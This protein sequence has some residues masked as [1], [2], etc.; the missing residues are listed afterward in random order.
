MREKLAQM[1]SLHEQIAKASAPHEQAAAWF[2]LNGAA[3][4]LAGLINDATK[5]FRGQ[6]E[7]LAETASGL[8]I[9]LRYC[10]IGSDWGVISTGYEKYLELWP[11]GPR[12]DDA[13]WHS[14]FES[15]CG[16]FEGS[17]EEYQAAADL[18]AEF[19]KRFPNSPRAPE[20]RKGL[21]E[22]LAGLAEAREEEKARKEK[23]QP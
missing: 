6:Y 18:Y 2:E 5:L 19:L 9:E 20:A 23:K 21:E 22:N 3:G 13:W 10:E 17:A 12:A 11:D 7:K 16:D 1:K 15:W 14:R 8:G 4:E